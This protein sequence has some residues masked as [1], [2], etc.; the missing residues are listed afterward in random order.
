[1]PISPEMLYPMPGQPR[2]AFLKNFIKGP[3]IIVGDYTYYDDPD[4]PEQFE[5][6]NVLYHFPFIGDQLVI[7]MYCAIAAKATFIM[8]GGNHRLDGFTSYPFGIF[9]EEY[10]E[11]LPERWPHHGDTVVGNDVWI[12]YDALI[13]P[14]VK[15]G[16]GAIIGARAVVTKDV[17]PYTIV[18][19]NPAK[20]I[21]R[22]FDAVT[23]EALLQVAWWDWPMD[24]ITRNLKAICNSDLG[25]LKAVR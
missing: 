17:P 5:T 11:A 19:G 25:V 16:H 8:N 2:L 24:K 15:I 3:N 7:G 10:R 6:R 9:G 14:G 13:M 18:G 23:V 12:G 21:R 4:G 20:E 22:R 1:M